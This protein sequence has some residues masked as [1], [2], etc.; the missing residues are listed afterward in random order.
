M[1]ESTSACQSRVR[2]EADV[3]RHEVRK[4]RDDEVRSISSDWKEGFAK[5]KAENDRRQKALELFV[6]EQMTE[7]QDW[8][9]DALVGCQK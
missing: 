7:I 8:L 4:E 9:N 6:R 5:L 3:R 2:K 1:S